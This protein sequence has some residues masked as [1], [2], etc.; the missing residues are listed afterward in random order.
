MLGRKQKCLLQFFYRLEMLWIFQA[1]IQTLIWDFKWYLWVCLN[2]ERLKG[3]ISLFIHTKSLSHPGSI[4]YLSS[5]HPH[6]HNAPYLEEVLGLCSTQTTLKRYWKSTSRQTFFFQQFFPL[7]S[8][9]SHKIITTIS[10]PFFFSV[11]RISSKDFCQRGLETLLQAAK[12]QECKCM[13]V[14]LGK[15]KSKIIAAELAQITANKYKTF[16]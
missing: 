10:F 1:P 15:D 16:Y 13:Y 12:K 14:C 5:Y 3:F 9:I 8:C 7:F 6:P 11:K 4:V 2:T